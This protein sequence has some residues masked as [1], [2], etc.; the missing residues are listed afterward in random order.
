MAQET[1]LA[2]DPRST[3][4]ELESMR[5]LIAYL[6]AELTIETLAYLVALAE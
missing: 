5:A 4:A 6:G 1:T 3:L 2:L